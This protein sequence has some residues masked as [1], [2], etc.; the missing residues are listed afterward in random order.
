MLKMVKDVSA[1]SVSHVRILWDPTDCSPSGYSV[2]GIFQARIL[3]WVAISF[4][5]FSSKVLLIYSY[6]CATDL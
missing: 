4:S 3:G 6:C 1:W 2:H 5:I